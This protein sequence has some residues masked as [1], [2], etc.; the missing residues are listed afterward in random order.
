MIHV[1]SIT[2]KYYYHG[3]TLLSDLQ[4]ACFQRFTFHSQMCPFRH[5]LLCRFCNRLSVTTVKALS[6]SFCSYA[7]QSLYVRECITA[8][9]GLW[10]TCA[11]G[12]IPH[13][14]RDTVM[15]ITENV[16]MKLI[17]QF[18]SLLKHLL[19]GQGKRLK[20]KQVKNNHCFSEKMT[21][22]M[23]M[24]PEGAR[25]KC[26]PTWGLSQHLRYLDFLSEHHREECRPAVFSCFFR[27]GYS[28]MQ[29]W[30]KHGCWIGSNGSSIRSKQAA[31]ARGALQLHCLHVNLFSVYF[32]KLFY[33]LA[34][35]C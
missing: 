23:V 13:V 33:L 30:Q 16:W 8:F 11:S 12:D 17:T 31:Q 15:V 28:P 25:L 14:H 24:E 9:S 19:R 4:L 10:G 29:Q 21:G 35:V 27:Q 32:W 6:T 3:W 2:S 18:H 20:E 1:I 34:T 22:G 5:C 26:M 7:W